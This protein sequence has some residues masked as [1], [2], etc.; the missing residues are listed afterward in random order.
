MLTHI[1]I[2]LLVFISQLRNSIVGFL[3][4]AKER[5][6]VY[7]RQAD[8]PASNSMCSHH[9]RNR[10]V[11]TGVFLCTS[12]EYSCIGFY[13]LF[14]GAG[15]S[16]VCSVQCAVYSVQCTGCSVQGCSSVQQCAVCR[17]AGA[18]KLT[19]IVVFDGNPC[20]CVDRV[21]HAHPSEPCPY[22]RHDFPHCGPPTSRHLGVPVVVCVCC[23]YRSESESNLVQDERG[24]SRMVSLTRHVSRV[25]S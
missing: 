25:V 23:K 19:E 21:G 11:E 18:D 12:C 2:A 7:N 17:C 16:A 24:G 5:L 1:S 8:N 6:Q 9:S 4:N 10:L 14:A 22:V 20:V 3:C 13:P 15:A